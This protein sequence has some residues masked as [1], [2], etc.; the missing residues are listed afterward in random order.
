MRNV[1]FYGTVGACGLWCG[2]RTFKLDSWCMQSSAVASLYSIL[3][4]VGLWIF[5]FCFIHPFFLQRSCENTKILHNLW[6]HFAKQDGQD[7][8]KRKENHAAEVTKIPKTK[9]QKYGINKTFN[10]KKTS[11]L[12]ERFCFRRISSY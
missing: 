1:R 12:M 9:R 4:S 7:G 8:K 10:R 5:H 3:L 2:G 6:L 11:W